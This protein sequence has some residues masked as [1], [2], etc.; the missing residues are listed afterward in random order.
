VHAEAA[1]YELVQTETDQAET[2]QAETDEAETD[3][4]ELVQA[5]IDQLQT[6]SIEP[7]P[8]LLD[9]Y[10]V[11]PI[12]GLSSPPERDKADSGPAVAGFELPELSELTAL[13]EE[14][15]RAAAEAAAQVPLPPTPPPPALAS[16]VVEELA[17]EFELSELSRR[18][19][20][21]SVRQSCHQAYVGSLRRRRPCS[22][23]TRFP[24][25]ASTGG[26]RGLLSYCLSRSWL[27]PGCSSALESCI[28]T[29]CRWSRG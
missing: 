25:A 13:T 8:A 4:A 21:L 17:S 7:S 5:E 16:F 18:N 14:A 3:E 20:P 24:S 19:L 28:T 11:E 23:L 12:E 1:P 22:W 2:D 9:D 27:A 26:C 15:L 29:A 10:E 6:G